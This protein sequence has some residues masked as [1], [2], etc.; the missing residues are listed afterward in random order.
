M[1]FADVA[2]QSGLDFVHFNGMSGELYFPE[3]MGSGVGLLDYDNDGDLDVYL[4]QGSMLG[5]DKNLEDATYPPASGA[6]ITDRLF[7][8]DLIRDGEATSLGF[9]DVTDIS[10]IRAAAYGMGVATGDYDND[11]D[12]DIYVTNF[13]S[14]QLWRN[15]GDGTFVDVTDAAGVDDPRWGVSASFVDYDRDGF[16]DLYVG[17]YVDF[18]FKN[19]RTCLW[20]TGAE[21]Y[22]SPSAY[23][24]EA[25][26][27]FHNRGDG[28]FEDVSAAAGVAA[29]PGATLGVIAAD[30]NS[31][32]WQDIYVANDGMANF[33]LMNDGKGGLI[34]EA[35]IAGVAVNMAG[36]PEASM[37]VTAGDF[38]GDG[39]LDLF[40]THLKRETNTLYVNDGTGWFEDL[41]A[42][43]GL[44]KSSFA[45]TGFGTAW[46]DYDQD[47]LLDLFIANGAVTH[48]KSQLLAGDKFPLRQRNQL[49]RNVGGG[50][51]EDVSDGAGVLFTEEAV[52]RGV[53]TGDI[54]NDG[55]IDVVV[56]N[57]SGPAQ[58]LRNN[59]DTRAST[60][61]TWLGICLDSARGNIIG[62]EIAVKSD[63]GKLSWQ[64]VHTD[65]S[66]ASASDS[67]VVILLERVSSADV[68]V[69]WPGGDLESFLA[70]KTGGYH[71]LAKGAGKE[72]AS[73]TAGAG[74][75]PD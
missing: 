72:V 14:N 67:R 65:G 25:D 21:D 74:P 46:L 4:V 23:E 54:D 48:V 75:M 42:G 52:S 55:D 49:F 37:G 41:T 38:D 7:R 31:D 60:P 17:N 15:E 32:G 1:Q 3:M 18:T 16:L 9:T 24:P 73:G 29:R 57:N 70:L 28:T 50:V 62:A 27:L 13:G 5:M 34:D 26:S 10:G 56:S 58:L 40:M 45:Y 61:P 19:H 63:D 8:N 39:D 59:N 66:Y 11:G 51:L 33:L 68:I 22:C 47:G 30:F 44:G 36:S 20:T 6:P 2:T 12:V 53:A 64:R 71:L 69:R 35:E 43:S